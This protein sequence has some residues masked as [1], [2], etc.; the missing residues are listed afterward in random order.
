MHIHFVLDHILN[1]LSLLDT[2]KAMG[3]DNISP[4]ILKHCAPALYLPIHHLFSLSLSS[5]RLPSEWCLH[6]IIPIFKSGDRTSVKNYRPISLLCSVSLVL[7]RLI[8]FKILPSISSK[9]SSY[10]F[11]FTKNRSTVQQLLLFLSKV[12]E[13]LELKSQTD[14][15]YLD[16]KKAFDSVSHNELLLKLWK[17]GITGGLWLWFKAYLSFRTQVVSVNKTLS[18]TLPVLSGVPQ[19]SILGP[20]LFLIFV[21]DLHLCASSSSV[22]LIVC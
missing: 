16:F 1:E 20:L 7:E 14:V 21:N 18:N 8:S 4:K 19:G 2:S 5:Q 11:G 15:I 22:L 17:F 9:I 12:F 13:S 10:Q 6:S 3:I